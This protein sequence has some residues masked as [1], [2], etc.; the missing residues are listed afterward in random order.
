MTNMFWG[1]GR[2]DD[3]FYTRMIEAGMKIHHPEGISTG[4]QT[5]RHIHDRHKRPRDQKSYHNQREV[6]AQPVGGV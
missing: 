4:Y 3:E 5:F 1:W 6:S 2:E